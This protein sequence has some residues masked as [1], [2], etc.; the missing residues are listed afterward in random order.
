MGY[1]LIVI[2]VLIL[3]L[4][5][6]LVDV[7]LNAGTEFQGNKE[8]VFDFVANIGSGEVVVEALDGVVDVFGVGIL[9][10]ISFNE[11]QI[12]NFRIELFYYL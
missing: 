7:N 8:R 1:N 4:N 12:D 2:W 6:A 5:V 3:D 10:F 9:R 11:I